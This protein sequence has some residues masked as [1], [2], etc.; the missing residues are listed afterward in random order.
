MTQPGLVYEPKY[1]GIRAIVEIAND[2]NESSASKR[3]D[4]SGSFGDQRARIPGQGCPAGGPRRRNRRRRCSAPALG[5]SAFRA[6]HPNVGRQIHASTPGACSWCY[7]L[8]DGNEDL[9]GCRRRA[10]PASGT[11]QAARRRARRHP[12][13]RD[14]TGRRPTDAPARPQ[15]GLGG[16][17]RQERAVHVPQRQAHTRVAQAQAPQAAGIRSRRLDGSTAVSPALWIA[18]RRLLRRWRRAAVGGLGRHRLRSE[19]AGSRRGL[20]QARAIA[21]VHLTIRSRPASRR[22]G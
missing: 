20:L 17:D 21:L 19:G 14:C 4:K 18:P 10:P 2:L 13:Q 5:L 16:S 8:R 9:R 11:H 7:L 3:N 6:N 1:D 15:R 12:A 22:T